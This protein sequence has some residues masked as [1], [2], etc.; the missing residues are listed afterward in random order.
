V[1]EAIMRNLTAKQIRKK[2]GKKEEISRQLARSMTF[3]KWRH[4]VLCEQQQCVE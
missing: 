4:R 2:E 3:L 1:I